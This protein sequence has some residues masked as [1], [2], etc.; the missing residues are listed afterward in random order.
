MLVALMLAHCTSGFQMAM[1]TLHPKRAP[2]PANPDRPADQAA[3]PRRRQTDAP[4]LTLLARTVY[5][6]PHP[7]RLRART[8]PVDASDRSLCDGWLSWVYATPPPFFG[9]FKPQQWA[10]LMYKHVDHHL[11]QFGV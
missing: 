3:R 11:R 10:I 6:R 4:Q 5:G 2:F 8:R 9:P 7:V 1:G